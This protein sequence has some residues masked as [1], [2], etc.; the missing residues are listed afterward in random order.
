M[1]ESALVSVILPFYHSPNLK[2]AIESIIAQTYQHFE[3]ILVNNNGPKEMLHVAEEFLSN[4]G[5]SIH[6]EHR[7]GVVFAMNKGIAIARGSYIMR[8][9]A[10]DYSFP[11]R[12]EKQLEAFK[13]NTDLGV[14]S[15]S[16]EYAGHEKN[17]GFR[18]YVDWLNSIHSDEEIRLNQFVELPMANPSLMFRKEI[19]ERFGLFEEGDFPEDYEYFLRL[20]QHGVRM[21]KVDSTVLKWVDSKSRLTRTDSRYSPDAFFRIKARYLAEWLKKHN[22]HHPFVLIWGGGRLSRRRSNYLTEYGIRIQGYIDVADRQNVIHYENIP[23]KESCF[24][25]SYVANRGAREEIRSFLVAK[26]MQEGSQFIMA[27]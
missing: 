7:Q 13:K 1:S 18:L 15:G 21:D 26:G 24:I 25:I 10:D 16:V 9:D 8:M 4:P 23:N 2:I 22:P 17:E 11:D 6:E 12:I 5:V 19:F 3:L 14:V 20:R 27:S